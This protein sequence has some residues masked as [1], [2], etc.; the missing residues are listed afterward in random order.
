MERPETLGEV[1][2]LLLHF[3]AAMLRSGNTAIRTREW[4]EVMARKMGCDATAVSLSVDTV[5]VNVTRAGERAMSMC[6]VGPPGIN[7]WRIGELEQLV[8]AA[9]PG[10]SPGGLI[11]RLIEIEAARPR[12]SAA[13]IAIAIGAASAGFAFLNGSGVLEMIAAGVGGATG[14]W[15]RSQLARHRVNQFGTAALSAIAASGTYVLAAELIDKIGW[16]PQHPAGF[17]SSVLFLVPGFPLIAALFDLLQHQTWAGISRLAYGVMLLLAVAFGLS[18]VVGIVGVDLSPQPSLEIPYLLK[19]LCRA[20]ASFVSGCAFAMLFN[21]AIRTILVVGILA[22]IANEI[23]LVLTDTGMMLAPAALFGALAVGVMALLVESHLNI[24]R[25]AT[26][27]PSI[28]IMVPGL[29]AFETIVFFNRGQMIDA[30]QALASC[31]FVIGAL[32][33]GIVAARFFYR[34]Y[35]YVHSTRP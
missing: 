28:I 8:R 34:P 11:A 18:V 32:A 20:V 2:D 9:E 12:F 25:I 10:I 6:E 24:P 19:L 22:L 16:G 15:L 26:V 30:L 3:G 7:A 23:R 1:L 33:M 17:I 4:M 14:Q 31:V 27:V 5:E 35:F 21:N 13:Q 29:Y